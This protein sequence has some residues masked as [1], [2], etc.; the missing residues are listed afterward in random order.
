MRQNLHTHSTWCDGKNT[1]REMAEAAVRKGFDILGFSGHA[2][3]PSWDG[4]M[5]VDDTRAYVRE[6][7]ELKEEYKDRLKIYLGI[8]A[9]TES[10]LLFKE[11]FEYVIGSCHSLAHDGVRM[12]VD[13]SRGVFE[14]M[15][16]SWYHGDY[17]E[18]VREYYKEVRRMENWEEADIIG[19]IDLITKFNED[20]AFFR[21]DDPYYVK[22][23]T[24]AIDVFAGKKILEVNTGAISRGYRKTPYPARNLLQYM[25]EKNVRITLTSDCHNAEYLDCCYPET[26]DMIKACGFRSMAVLTENGFIDMDIDQFR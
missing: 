11:P 17:R 3:V 19:H 20:E 4:S 24:D 16:D 18:F 9:D 12:A 23:A 26:L 5:S 13:Y 6:V 2:C 21:F 15:L 25:K 14:F 10:R 1:T 22:E 7:L 8:E